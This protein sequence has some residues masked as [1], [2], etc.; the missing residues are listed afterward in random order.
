MHRV[1][2]GSLVYIVRSSLSEGRGKSEIS[3]L[4]VYMYICDMITNGITDHLSN[5]VY[6]KQSA[7]FEM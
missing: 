5:Y 2:T 6:K 7:S 4:S 3:F 1:L